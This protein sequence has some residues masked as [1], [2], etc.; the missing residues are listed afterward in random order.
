MFFDQMNPLVLIMLILSAGLAAIL[1]LPKT[2]TPICVHLTAQVS[3]ILAYAVGLL[4]L[5]TF[6]K[7]VLGFQYLAR[8]NI[9]QDYNISLSFGADGI[10]MTFLLLTLFVFPLLFL[11]A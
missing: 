1:L 9:M 5:L 3:S 11:S 8:I 10:S 4:S 2:L 6:D 7:S